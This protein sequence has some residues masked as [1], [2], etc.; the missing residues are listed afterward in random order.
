MIFVLSL[1][2]NA[3]YVLWCHNQPNSDTDYGIFNVRTDVNAC[4]CTRREGGGV[5][6]HVRE[7]ALKV[8]SG[9]KSLAAPVN[10]TCVSGVTV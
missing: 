8:D 9:R 2:G 1:I 7:S 5:R 3:G 4:D 10:R 6:T